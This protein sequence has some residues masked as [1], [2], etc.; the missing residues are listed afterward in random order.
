MAA[1]TKVITQAILCDAALT[2]TL[3]LQFVAN[4]RMSRRKRIDEAIAE[5]DGT[6]GAVVE[7]IKEATGSLATTSA[8]LQQA[9]SETLGRTAPPRTH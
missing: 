6:I 7:A 9:A 1:G 2:S 4:S 3:Y 5:F 8:G